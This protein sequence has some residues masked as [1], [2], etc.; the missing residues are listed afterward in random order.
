[1][2]VDAWKLSVKR[3][4]EIF[5][6]LSDESLYNEVSPGRNTGVYLLGHLVAITDRM[7]PLLGFGDA[8]YPELFE[9]FVSESE[10]KGEPTPLISDLKAYWS[11]VNERLDQKL[12]E[13]RSEQFFDRHTSVSEEDFQKEPHRN[14]LN[15]IINRTNHMEYHR[16]QLIFLKDK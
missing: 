11:V 9:P 4:T 15:V 8:K 3:T 1:M 13:L 16:G 5:D 10:K 12:D 6:S 7:M 14:R 2:A